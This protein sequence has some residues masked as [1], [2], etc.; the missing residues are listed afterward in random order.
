MGKLCKTLFFCHPACQ[1]YNRNDDTVWKHYVKTRAIKKGPRN[2]CTRT[3]DDESFIQWGETI[4][5]LAILFLG[6]PVFNEI[7]L[8][9][10][11]SWVIKG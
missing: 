2:V 9:F 10:S 11:L 7:F 4:F 5:E 6:A 1:N 8:Q 3:Q